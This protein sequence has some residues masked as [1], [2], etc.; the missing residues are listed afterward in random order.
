MQR[1]PVGHTQ[2][3][4]AR[5][6]EHVGDWWNILILRDAFY[7]LRRFDE[8][9]TS[10]DIATSTLTKRLNA[11]VT[12]GILERVRYSA[13]PPRDEYVLTARGRDFR[14]VLLSLVAWGNRNFAPEGKA[15]DLVDAETGAS[16]EPVLADRISGRLIERVRVVAGPVA[17][18]AMRRRI[19][20][21]PDV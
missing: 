18:E 15:L 4:V 20:G 8:F 19:E 14:P 7:G 2:C 10:L 12:A 13:H 5:G 16:I 1:K 21:R 9:Q 17:D 6:L 3:P 11:L